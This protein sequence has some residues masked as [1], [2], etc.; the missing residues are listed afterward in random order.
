MKKVQDCCLRIQKLALWSARNLKLRKGFCI[1][2]WASTV[3]SLFFSNECPRRIFFFRM[4]GQ[5]GIFLLK[6]GG[7]YGQFKENCALT[8]RNC[9]YLWQIRKNFLREISHQS[10]EQDRIRSLYV[11][12]CYQSCF[13]KMASIFETHPT[14]LAF[15]KTKKE[16]NEFRIFSLD[17]CHGNY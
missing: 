4:W 5:G 6:R 2:H 15:Q 10:G 3:F 13:A 7:V 14:V 1:S 9:N 16:T 8:N 17:Q 12:E 11:S